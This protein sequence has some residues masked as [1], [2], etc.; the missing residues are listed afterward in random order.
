VFPPEPPDAI[1]AWPDQR[2]AVKDAP[3]FG[4]AKR[5]LDSEPRSGVDQTSTGG[6]DGNIFPLVSFERDFGQRIPTP[7]PP[8]AQARAR[9]YNQSFSECQV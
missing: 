6:V 5:T 9:Q 8:A 4:A 3:Q 2:V 1:S 7:P